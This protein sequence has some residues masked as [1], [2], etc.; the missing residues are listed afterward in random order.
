MASFMLRSW[1]PESNAEFDVAAFCAAMAASAPQCLRIPRCPQAAL[2]V[3][4]IGRGRRTAGWPSKRE[5]RGA[6]LIFRIGLR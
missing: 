2:L 5:R 3:F 1:A 4:A 6:S